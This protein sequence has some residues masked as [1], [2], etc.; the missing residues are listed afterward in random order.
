MPNMGMLELQEETVSE[1]TFRAVCFDLDGTL[2]PMD[3]DEFMR[4]YFERIAGYM[5][6]HGMDQAAFLSALKAGTKA[7]AANHDGRTNEAAFWSAFFPAFE[8]VT[9]AALTEDERQQVR[10]LADA[11]Y[12]E[13]F[14]HIGDGFE[15]NPLAAHVIRVLSEKGYPLVLATMPMFPRRAVEHRLAWA[16]VDPDAFVRITSYENS[17]S[18]K[19]KQTYFAEVLA[20]LGVAG[21]DVCM[22]GN[23]TMED[24]AFLDLGVEGFLVTDWLLNPIDVDIQQMR[25][26]TFAELDAWASEL[27]VCTHPAED[28]K[29]GVIPETE[30]VSALERNAVVPIDL[31]DAERKA[32][33]VA[34][35]V[36]GDHAPGAAR[37]LRIAEEG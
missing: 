8:Q 17:T 1:Q 37:D 20:S 19:P 22:V 26:G 13:D 32:Q 27:P 30:T 3:I 16:G 14:G 36:A 35:A 12:D 31:E 28:I 10:A 33:A 9:N 23:N 29:A 2:L 4:A 5:E 21:S 7:M 34:Q 25:H 6:A 11:F 15:A 24:F 18:V